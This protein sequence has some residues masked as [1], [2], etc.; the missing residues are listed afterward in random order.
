MP[1]AAGQTSSPRRPN[2]RPNQASARRDQAAASSG[3]CVPTL[4]GLDTLHHL[5]STTGEAGERT[6]H[7]DGSSGSD[8]DTKDGTGDEGDAVESGTL[9]A[10][11]GG[12]GDRPNEGRD[13]K[14]TRQTAHASPRQVATSPTDDTGE[15]ESEAPSSPHSSAPSDASTSHRSVIS[16]MVGAGTS[17]EVPREAYGQSAIAAD[18]PLVSAL[19]DNLLQQNHTAQHLLAGNIAPVGPLPSA[20]MNGGGGGGAGRGVTTALDFG[21]EL[22]G[23]LENIFPGS[24]MAGAAASAVLAAPRVVC[25]LDAP[26]SPSQRITEDTVT[27]LNQAQTYSM[28]LTAAPGR[29]TTAFS[30]RLSNGKSITELEPQY[31]SWLAANPKRNVLEIDRLAST[32]IKDVRMLPTQGT[33]M[34][35]WDCA[36][37]Q[38]A[39][40]S[41]R[42]NC[43]STDF[44]PHRRGGEKGAF[45]RLQLDTADQARGDHAGIDSST[46]IVKIFKG[47]ADRRLK[48]DQDKLKKHADD[49]KDLLQF[50]GSKLQTALVA[51]NC[52]AVLPM[53]CFYGDGCDVK[54]EVDVHGGSAPM[55]AACKT[56]PIRMPS[57][58]DV[59]SARNDAYREGHAEVMGR[60]L[61][62]DLDSRRRAPRPRVALRIT[63]ASTCAD[64]QLWLKENHFSEHLSAFSNYNG[65][66]LLKLDKSD[67]VAICS[68]A[69][70]IRLYATLRHG[71]EP[72]SAPR[73]LSINTYTQTQ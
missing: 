66:L 17:A 42:V 61:S 60:T 54:R 73:T 26:T 55:F 27:Y 50:Q 51:S 68:P 39:V 72:P 69:E 14:K 25:V 48:M 35:S 28:R 30:M 44:A 33:M 52:G 38:S 37:G 34:F 53:H 5:L 13:R 19:G 24:H 57:P 49:E 71:R 1:E 3:E 56:E 40:A 2:A 67:F 22:P 20:A 21:A 65:H 29:Y 12:S 32:G 36:E 63:E 64:V 15:E 8:G 46:C 62:S 4:S 59:S 11:D 10:Q 58:H 9:P 7:D 47:G 45:L 23:L 41:F 70:G 31:S 43:L 6:E 18:V 16:R